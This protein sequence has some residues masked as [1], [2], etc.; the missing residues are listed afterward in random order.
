MPAWRRSDGRDGKKEN[1]GA[2]FRLKLDEYLWHL[3]RSRSIQ[4]FW[5]RLGV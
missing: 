1:R 4:G 3:L 5:S 2:V